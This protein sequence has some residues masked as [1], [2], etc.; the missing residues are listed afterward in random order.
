MWS[1]RCEAIKGY[2][3]VCK[4]YSEGGREGSIFSQETLVVSLVY[5][6]FVLV[7]FSFAARAVLYLYRSMS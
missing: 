4:V 2:L 1:Y 7:I 6:F 5:V 3:N